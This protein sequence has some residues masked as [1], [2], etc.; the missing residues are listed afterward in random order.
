MKLD[1]RETFEPIEQQLR[2]ALQDIH[3]AAV[4]HGAKAT[5]RRAGVRGDTVG[6][7]PTSES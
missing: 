1:C 6:S 2:R 3:L 5:Q 7:I 4:P